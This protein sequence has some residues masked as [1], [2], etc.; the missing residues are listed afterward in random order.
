ME[1]N[2]KVRTCAVCV[3]SAYRFAG[4]C[5]VSSRSILP[6]THIRYF[7]HIKST[8]AIHS[9]GKTSQNSF[10]NFGKPV[11]IRIIA[12][13]EAA[14]LSAVL[15][16]ASRPCYEKRHQD[17]LAYQELCCNFEASLTVYVFSGTGA[18]GW[19]ARDRENRIYPSLDDCSYCI[20]ALPSRCDKSQSV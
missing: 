19:E 6:C 5:L 20:R 2:V 3:V 10:S 17:V 18:K 14:S 8:V 15:N 7:A 12:S 16:H 11:F 4:A 9:K 13:S 1:Q